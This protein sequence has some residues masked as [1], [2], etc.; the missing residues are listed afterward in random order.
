MEADRWVHGPSFF[1]FPLFFIVYTTSRRAVSN[2]GRNRTGKEEKRKLIPPL[3]C[4]ELKSSELQ[5]YD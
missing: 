3:G 1:F 5:S 4:A 2:F